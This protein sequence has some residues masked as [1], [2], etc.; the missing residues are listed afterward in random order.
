MI[1]YEELRN[2]IDHYLIECFKYRRS[3]AYLIIATRRNSHIDLYLRIRKVE[4]LFPLDCLVIA[5]LGF[6]K[7]RI[8]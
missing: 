6:S 5:R 4:S 2:D 8:A 3:L 1:E 7:E